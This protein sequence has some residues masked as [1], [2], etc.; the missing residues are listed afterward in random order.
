VKKP[1]TA[2]LRGPGVALKKITDKKLKG[3]L[4]HNERLYRESQAKA[5]KVNEWLQPSEAGYLEAEGECMLWVSVC[6]YACV[7]VYLCVYVRACVCVSML[8]RLCLLPL[9]HL[10]RLIFSAYWHMHVQGILILH[11]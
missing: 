3:R 11:G 1:K 4:K 2:Q 9:V 8:A 5:S 7:C 6:R 10:S